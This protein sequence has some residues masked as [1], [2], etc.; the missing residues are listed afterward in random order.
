MRRKRASF[1]SSRFLLFEIF[2]SRMYVCVW[3]SVCVCVWVCECMWVCVCGW[4]RVCDRVFA[5]ERVQ[6]IRREWMRERERLREME[7]SWST[8]QSRN[9][10]VRQQRLDLDLDLQQNPERG[11]FIWWEKGEKQE[12]CCNVIFLQNKTSSPVSAIIETK[13]QTLNGVIV[14]CLVSFERKACFYEKLKFYF[15]NE[16]G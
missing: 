5:R 1:C 12:A 11:F 15:S 6:E 3:V 13:T 7:D 14:N 10:S 2:C 8:G 16:T 9:S 4:G